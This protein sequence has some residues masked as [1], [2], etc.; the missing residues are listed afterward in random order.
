M[1]LLLACSCFR[2]F[3]QVLTEATMAE[4]PRCSGRR[5][6]G[7]ATLALLVWCLWRGI[8]VLARPRP[9]VQGCW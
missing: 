4:L 2:G 8:A 6:F 1:G 3:Q 5:A 7:I 9:G